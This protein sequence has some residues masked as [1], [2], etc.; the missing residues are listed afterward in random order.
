M[1]LVSPSGRIASLLR[2]RGD[3]LSRCALATLQTLAIFWFSPG[4]GL[5]LDDAWIHQVVART[6]A[7]TGT[8]GY[9]PGQ[10]GAAATSYLWAALLAVNFKLLHIEP[11]LWALLLNG[12]CALASGQLLYSLLLRAR[13]DERENDVGPAAWRAMSFGASLFAC[14]SPNILWFVCSGMEAM[15]FIALSLLAIATA[16][17]RA[18]RTAV[19]RGCDF[20]RALV[21]GFAAGA[22]ALLRPEASPLGGLL[23]A[24][25]LLRSSRPQSRDR[26]AESFKSAARARLDVA[27]AS[28]ITLPWASMVAIYVGSNVVKTGH[29]LPSTLAGRRWLWF[30]TSIGLSRGDRVLDFLDAWATRLS[31]YT[32]DT[33]LAVLWI[34]TALAGYGALR[35]VRS[36]AG[37]LG[38]GPKP[39]QASS[40]DG[41]RDGVALLFA[42][43]LFHASFYALLLPTPG[44]GGRYQPLT[45]LLF[46]ACLPLGTAFV[47]RELACIVGVPKSVRFAW[48]AAVGIVPWIALGVPVAGSL[49]NA[50]ALAVAHIHATELG[51]GKYVSELPEGAVA[52]FDI[53]G[54][55][56]ASKRRVLD[57]GGLSETSTAALL[58]SG[59]VSE[60]LA[61]NHVRWI[62]LPE[63]TEPVLPVFDDFRSRLH[64]RDNPALRI[65]PVRVFET[66]LDKWGPAIAATWNAA[67]KQVVYEVHYTGRPG[68]PAV[69]MV[70]PSAVR[71]VADPSNQVSRRD[72]VVAEH[73]LAML[74]AWGMEVDVRITSAPDEADGASASSAIVHA[75]SS[76]A[77][78]APSETGHELDPTITD[79][80]TGPCVVRL[81]WWGFGVDGCSSI[82]DPRTLRAMAYEQAG[83]YLDVGDLGGA[84]RAIPQVFAQARRRVDPSFHP[85][86]SP[87]NPPTPGGNDLGSSRAGGMGLALLLGVLVAAAL[88]EAGARR[89]LRVWRLV[90]IARARLA[91]P[92][93]ALL[94]VTSLV[95]ISAPMGCARPNVR[96]AIE[97]GRGA[98]QA[99]IDSGGSVN[100]E[101][102]PES[103]PLLEAASVGDAEI[104]A[105]LLERGARLDVRAADGAS[106]LHLAARRGHAATVAVLVS[107]MLAEAAKT[108]TPGKEP[109]NAN[110]VLDETAGP[111]RRTAL[112]EAVLAGSA[113]SVRALIAGGANA[114]KA[115]SFGQTPLH[116]L[117][118]IEPSRAAMIAPLLQMADPRLPDARGFSALHAAA[119]TDDA[120]LLRSI[121]SA[122]RSD[123]LAARTPAGE[124]ALDVA[125]RYGR[126]RA[127]E[128]LLRSGAEID[129]DGVWPPL[130]A[131]ARMDAVERAAVLLA[132][133][134]DADRRFRGKTALELARENGS[135][136]VAALLHERAR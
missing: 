64:L 17:A 78:S 37:W 69:P 21:S 73:M 117:A 54:V 92:S 93:V 46:T 42:W 50:N 9:A 99:A 119:A 115:D 134:A 55:G 133:G 15:P 113:E 52:S 85:P 11:S 39:T 130:H 123:V 136:R 74:A 41:G 31:N 26:G 65:E 12:A 103:A 66:P 116:L 27:R 45:P 131:A 110:A 126:D 97:G 89:N 83:R 125:L 29:A 128:A 58:E 108:S 34:F 71:S 7:E 47:L 118:Y 90:E 135:K 124:T 25:V 75:A 13:G 88:V 112:H 22:L 86:L 51:A 59:R 94:V 72:R 23:A 5:P 48:F 53:G 60:W 106:P 109:T 80:M 121:L 68:P 107:A 95:V 18:E 132:S 122:D 19:D 28:A 81:G 1:S 67:P 77:A 127:G 20:K 33:S 4:R 98:V 91:L 35:L 70:A 111:R 62:V 79:K 63:T 87:L 32:F 44:H 96:R 2:G 84:L 36:R 129:R 120:P 104:V 61:S 6:F 16:T 57:L 3:L 14:I 40:D 30:E 82:S 43:A 100:T 102:G 114:N 38:N 105:L 56:Y 8:L 24:W 49:R 10:H 101:A 76:V